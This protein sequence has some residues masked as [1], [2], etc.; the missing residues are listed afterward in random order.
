MSRIDTNLWIGTVYNAHNKDFMKN[1]GITHVLSCAKEFGRPEFDIEYH[2]L[3]I[4]DDKT[5]SRTRLLFREGAAVIDKWIRNH[6]TIMV[7]CHAGISRSVSVVIAYYILYKGYTYDAAYTLIKERRPKMNI[8]P[9]YVPILR[10][11]EKKNKTRKASA[12]R[13]LIFNPAKTEYLVGKESYFIKNKPGLSE[14]TKKELE[15]L[16]MRKV[17]KP[18]DSTDPDEIAYYATLL[19]KIKW[20]VKGRITFGDIRYTKINDKWYSY[21][22]PQYVP[23]GTPFSFPGGQ[24]KATNTNAS[25]GARELVEET[26]IDSINIVDTDTKRG[27]YKI[28][29]YVP[30][31]TEYKEILSKI[32]AKNKSPYAELHSLQFVPIH[33]SKIS[34]NAAANYRA[35]KFTR[36]KRQVP[37][38][39]PSP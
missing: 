25:C 10:S 6:K 2:H 24:P 1:H 36:K 38:L 14:D 27:N 4:T 26:G 31:E 33:S 34:R 13:I 20:I 12:S 32:A 29:Y 21:T 23:D 28:L 11:F 22:I 18:K 19:K 15:V 5:N 16:F 7:H 39:R 17:H 37:K 3:P 30:N 35:L 8:H 9:L